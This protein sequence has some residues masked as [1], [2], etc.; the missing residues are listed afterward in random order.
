MF[1]LT[2]LFAVLA[3]STVLAASG[4][5]LAAPNS[6][7]P[8]NPAKITISV[9]PEAV[10]PGGRAQVTVTLTPASGVKINRY[11]KIKVNV[12]AQE[13]LVA[14]AGAEVGNDSPPPLDNPDSNYF[15][16]V[17]P[18]TLK[19]DLDDSISSGSHEIEGKLTYFYCVAKSGFCAPKK[20]PVKIAVNVK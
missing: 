6:D 9:S 10:A 19:L 3:V 14:E 4:A 16:V 1:N 5:V 15:D 2:R 11:P 13:G 8:A 20:T 17:E 18:V 12:P 7:Q